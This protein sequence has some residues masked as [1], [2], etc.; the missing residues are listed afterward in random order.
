MW[1]SQL[2]IIKPQLAKMPRAIDSGVTP[3]IDSSTQKPY[4]YKR[5][6]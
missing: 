3:S 1:G 4:A 2:I 5:T 6:P